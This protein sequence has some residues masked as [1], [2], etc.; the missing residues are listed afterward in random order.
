MING[1]SVKHLRTVNFIL[2]ILILIA[3]LVLGRALVKSI[4]SQKKPQT[5]EREVRTDTPLTPLKNIMTYAPILENNPFGTP[6][7]LIPIASEYTAKK[8]ASS[9]ELILHGTVT[10]P[11]KMS[12]AILMDNSHPDSPG[13]EIFMHGDSVYNFGKLTA[14]EKEWIEL[15]DGVETSKIYLIDL[16]KEESPARG[17]EISNN[18]FAR[19]VSEKEYLLDRQRVQQSLDNPEQILTDARLLPN[20]KNGKQEGFK[21]FEI[22]P[23]GL[24]E[25]LGL[26]NGD[27]LLR[28]NNLEI[29]NPEVAIQAMSAL[30]GMDAVNLDI[31]RNNA[32]MTMTYQIR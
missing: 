11:E 1:F 22:R 27:I 25:S 4:Y 16:L 24:Y 7:K 14:I 26:R 20:I 3:F 29:S 10:G 31:V 32:K 17:A 19:K 30:R 6:Q 8:Q 13:Q 23:G 15:S 12:Y 2:I 5:A 28:V 9:S 18:S 21:I